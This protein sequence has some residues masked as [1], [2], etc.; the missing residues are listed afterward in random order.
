MKFGQKTFWFRLQWRFASIHTSI[1]TDRQRQKIATQHQTVCP[2]SMGRRHNKTITVRT[3]LKVNRFSIRR[4]IKLLCLSG[5]DCGITRTRRGWSSQSQR[6]LY[7]H[8]HITFWE[9]T[10]NVPF[11]EVW[12]V[13]P[14]SL[15]HGVLF[16]GAVSIHWPGLLVGGSSEESRSKE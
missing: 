3:I 16:D 15:T 14:A 7:F 11:K 10:L 8:L 1:H 9:T 12:T 6:W 2:P 13:H 5:N 4:W